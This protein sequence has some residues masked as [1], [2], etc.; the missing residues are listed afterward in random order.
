LLIWINLQPQGAQDE[1]DA[2]SNIKNP[3]LQA[4]AR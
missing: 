1:Q 2:Q 4:K 3:P